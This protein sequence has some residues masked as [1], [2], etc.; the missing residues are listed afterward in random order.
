MNNKLI[1]E[2]RVLLMYL[3][4]RKNNTF[5]GDYNSFLNGYISNIITNKSEIKVIEDLDNTN[6]YKLTTLVKNHGSYFRDA[7]SFYLDRPSGM[8][9]EEVFQVI[10][11]NR[12]YFERYCSKEYSNVCS[13]TCRSLI[14]AFGF[15]QLEE[16]DIKDRLIVELFFIKD[17]DLS[18]IN[19]KLFK[20]HFFWYEENAKL[21]EEDIFAIYDRI[22]SNI[23]RKLRNGE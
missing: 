5:N 3:K 6:I 19:S 12:A 8:T 23:A 4:A 11:H 2:C 15:S 10:A 22:D 16:C 18:F 21:D 20:E 14:N 9:Q 13:L 1:N 7:K 17:Y